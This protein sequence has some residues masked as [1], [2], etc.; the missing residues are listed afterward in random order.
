MKAITLKSG[1]ILKIDENVLNNMEL[2][3][4]LADMQTDEDLLSISKISKM[5]FGEKKKDVYDSFRNDKGEVPIT[6]IVN[7][8]KDV[9]ENIGKTGKK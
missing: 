2:I 6:D 4:T 5:I 8:I 3:D 1:Y 9:F 7:A